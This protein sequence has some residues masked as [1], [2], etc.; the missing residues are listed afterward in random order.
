MIPKQEMDWISRVEA[1]VGGLAD[2]ARDDMLLASAIP[3][4]KWY[5]NALDKCRAAIESDDYISDV[6]EAA[7]VSTNPHKEVL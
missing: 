1:S 7:L 6:G 5:A 2:A 4:L 3:L